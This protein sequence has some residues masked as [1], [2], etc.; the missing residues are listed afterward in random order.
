MTTRRGRRWGM[1]LARVRPMLCSHQGPLLD[2]PVPVAPCPTLCWMH[3]WVAS[4]RR[5]PCLWTCL[6][7]CMAWV[8][9]VAKAA[10]LLQ[11]AVSPRAPPCRARA[12][13]RPQGLRAALRDSES[14][15][16]R[17]VGKWGKL[18]SRQL[19]RLYCRRR[20]PSSWSRLQ[21]SSTGAA[22]GH[23]VGRGR[24]VGQH[25]MTKSAP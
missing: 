25:G 9:P 1:G 3:P 5:H 24:R 18:G 10:L 22:W 2:P 11:V 21:H 4:P 12:T 7:C 17:I 8:A 13:V 19:P 14:A 20:R 6:G 15:L 23:C 16:S